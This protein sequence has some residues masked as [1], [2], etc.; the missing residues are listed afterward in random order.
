M[1]FFPYKADPDVWMKD[2][3]THY[4]YVCVYVDDLAVMMKEPSAFFAELKER[5]YKLNQSINHYK[6][7]MVILRAT[8]AFTSPLLRPRNG[9]CQTIWGKNLQRSN[10]I[11]RK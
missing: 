4:E 2:C 11:P 5:K 8:E 1:Q 10:S 3:G 9:R 6:D 7:Y